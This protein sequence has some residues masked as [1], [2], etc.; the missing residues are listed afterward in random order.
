MWT[1]HLISSLVGIH[2]FTFFSWACSPHMGG[3]E[4]CQQPIR[5]GLWQVRLVLTEDLQTVEHLHETSVRKDEQT[6]LPARNSN[7]A[8]RTT[9]A[10]VF[11]INFLDQAEWK[12]LLYFWQFRCLTAGS[13]TL[14]VHTRSYQ[15]ILFSVQT[16]ELCNALPLSHNSCAK[17]QD[18]S[19]IWSEISTLIQQS[20]TN[21][22]CLD[23]Q[24]AETCF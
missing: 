9:C 21:K 16:V 19:W 20:V 22:P 2:I 18:I 15:L 6:I 8:L 7:N 1:L 11:T 17:I 23:L 10:S 24:E 5:A 13:S 4:S 12:L 3:T 14:H